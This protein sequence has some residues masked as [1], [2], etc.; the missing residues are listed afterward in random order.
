VPL[1]AESS[2]GHSG[3]WRMTEE[4]DKE[5]DMVGCGWLLCWRLNGQEE[6]TSWAGFA[7][8]R[9]FCISY[10]KKCATIEN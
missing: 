5:E 8:G 10:M 9:K 2:R 1:G 3:E 6:S 4:E 7:Y